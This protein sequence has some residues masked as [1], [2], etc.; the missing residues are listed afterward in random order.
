MRFIDYSHERF[1]D[2]FAW[3]EVYI[4]CKDLTYASYNKS[5]QSGFQKKSDTLHSLLVEAMAHLFYLY[6]EDSTESGMK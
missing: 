1:I 5:L 4:Q 3:N 6:K 2:I